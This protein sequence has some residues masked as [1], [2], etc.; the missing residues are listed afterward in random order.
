VSAPAGFGKTSLLTAWGHALQRAGVAVA[1]YGL[2]AGDNDPARFIAAMVA[3]FTRTLDG[4]V[5]LH[6]G[7]PTDVQQRPFPIRAV[8]TATVSQAGSPTPA[9]P[10]P[11]EPG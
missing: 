3:A 8:P 4:A 5:D 7:T 1:W 11:V 10:A 6:H 2:E 9:H